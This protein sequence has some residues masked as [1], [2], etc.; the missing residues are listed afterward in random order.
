MEPPR[1]PTPA[2][3]AVA[4]VPLRTGGKSRLGAALPAA[5]RDALVLAMLD[6]VVAALRGAGIDDVRVLA[7]SATAAEIAEGRGLASIPDPSADGPVSHVGIDA[8]L[9]AAVD[10]ALADLPLTRVRVVVAA[11]LPRLSAAEVAA[12]LAD[13]A[14]V[15]IAPTAGG[16]TALLRLAAGVSL[17]AR[18]GPGSAGAHARAAQAAGRSV[19]VLDLPGARHDVDAADDLTALA[20][21]LDGTSPGPATT[22]FLAGVGG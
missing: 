19:S 17:P 14:D 9:R 6:D 22:A 5:A 16:G 21:P 15:A 1:D 8:P 3:G 7:G 10:A 11:D 18:Y 4:L 20:G 13:P 12:V 2:H